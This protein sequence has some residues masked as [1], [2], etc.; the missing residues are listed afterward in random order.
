MGFWRPSAPYF[1][2]KGGTG[3]SREQRALKAHKKMIDRTDVDWKPIGRH[4]HPQ[5]PSEPED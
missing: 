2:V 4:Q 5:L 1:I 3:A